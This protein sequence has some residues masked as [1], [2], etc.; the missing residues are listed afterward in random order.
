MNIPIFRTFL[1]LNAFYFVKAQVN[2]LFTPEK[3]VFFMLRIRNHA[4]NDSEAFNF[5][6][7]EKLQ[8]SDFD[9]RKPVTFQIHGFMG[10]PRME[11]QMVLSK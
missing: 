4:F 11:L 5:V 10:S 6:N 8:Q 9:P 1:F 7:R 2:P 3:D